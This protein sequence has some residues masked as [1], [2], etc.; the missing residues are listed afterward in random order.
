MTN[1]NGTK[2][3][4]HKLI[5]NP[6][7]I[8]LKITQ[9]IIYPFRLPTTIKISKKTLPTTAGILKDTKS[10]IF[11]PDVCMNLPARKYPTIDIAMFNIGPT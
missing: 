11:L 8:L 6:Q 10:F 1:A 3:T 7:D 4:I 2:Y 9:N 5:K